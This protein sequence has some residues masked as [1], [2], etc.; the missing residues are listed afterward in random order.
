MTDQIS[1]LVENEEVLQALN[2]LQ[3][4][5][6]NLQPAFTQAGAKLQSSINV[7]FQT[8]VSPAGVA[9]AALKPSTQLSYSKKYKGKTP[10]S[11]LD[12]STNG[13]LKSL[14]RRVNPNGVVVGFGKPYAAY[15]EFGTKKMER[16]GLMFANPNLG[17]LAQKDSTAI[18]TIFN[19]FL[20]KL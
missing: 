9:W 11:L 19:N 4:K 15:H 16:R 3:A 20:S 8:K 1:I 17:L 2:R 5:L 10:G 18:E 13:L 12:R 6:G 14:T 7:R